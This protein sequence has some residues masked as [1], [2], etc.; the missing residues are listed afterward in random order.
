MD[1]PFRDGVSYLSRQ[2]EARARQ[3]ESERQ[4]KSKMVDIVIKDDD[5]ES[6]R[7]AAKVR[8]DISKWKNRTTVCPLAS[9]RNRE[10]QELTMH[11]HFQNTSIL[12]LMDTSSPHTLKG[13]STAFKSDWYIKSSA[14]NIPIL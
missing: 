14:R 9:S 4:D 12:P 1:A 3:I 5:V 10:P 6:L 7:F 11:S 2:E 13:A 8:A